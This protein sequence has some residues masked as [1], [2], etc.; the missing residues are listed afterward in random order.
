[1]LFFFSNHQVFLYGLRHYGLYRGFTTHAHLSTKLPKLFSGF[2]FSI[3]FSVSRCPASAVRQ[4]FK[5]RPSNPRHCASTYRHTVH[6]SVVLCHLRPKLVYVC[7]SVSVCARTV[8]LCGARRFA[9]FALPCVCLAFV[10][11]F[12]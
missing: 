10:C 7:V 3:I 2:L 1:L 9:A 12:L 6:R 5:V 4:R 8:L 11:V